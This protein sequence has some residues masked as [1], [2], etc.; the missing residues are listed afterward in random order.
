MARAKETATVAGVRITSPDRV[1][2]EGQGITKRALA[3]YWVAVKDRALPQVKGRP[4]TMVRCPEG[5]GGECFYQRRESRGFPDALRR[6]KVEVDGEP[7]SYLAVESVA[8]LVGLVQ[9]GVLEVHTWSARRD[10]LDR[11]DRMVFDLDPDE[12]LPWSAV[13]D[14]AREL[15]ELLEGLGLRTFVKT[16]GGKGLHVVVP[17]SRGATWEQVHAAARDVAEAMVR[18]APDRY[19][20][21][22]SR[23]AREGRIFIDW[24]RNAWSASAVAAYSPRARP[25]A[26]VS[27][28]LTW[29]ELAGGVD[30]GE[31]TVATVPA[32]L[33]A[34]RPDPWAEYEGARVRLTRALRE[35]MAAAAAGP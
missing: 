27:T 30:P 4:L 15:R 9:M 8:G 25:G 20:A 28:P 19:L 2:Y 21:H 14:A 6:V 18:R 10:R 11:P 35:R 26:P 24:L 13:V 12:G 34:G 17:L 7:A 29:D 31:L 16:T 32:R 23:Q 5:P 33:A 3:E 22:A 1:L